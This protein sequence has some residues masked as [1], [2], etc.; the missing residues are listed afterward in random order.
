MA[1]SS[2]VVSG[3]F[4]FTRNPIYLSLLLY[5]LAWAVYLSNLWTLLLVPMYVLY[6]NK[7]QIK[8]EERA[9]PSLFEWNAGNSRT[10]K[11][12]PSS[13]P[14]VADKT[15]GD[16]QSGAHSYSRIPGLAARPAMCP[17]VLPT[18]K[19]SIVSG[20]MKRTFRKATIMEPCPVDQST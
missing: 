7:F 6:V 14:M 15:M 3:V 8:P 4:R 9:L 19:P 16:G 5:L 1:A 12:T 13:D 17:T 2:L 11:L 18:T 10:W 20:S